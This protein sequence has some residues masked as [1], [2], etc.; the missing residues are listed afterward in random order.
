MAIGVVCV[1]RRWI[2]ETAA[3]A[4]VRVN[5]HTAGLPQGW[6]VRHNA[7][8]VNGLL[9][10]DLPLVVPRH[11][12]DAAAEGG[13]LCTV[14]VGVVISSVLC[15][16]FAAS[17]CVVGGDGCGA[18]TL[19]VVVDAGGEGGAESLCW[20]SGCVLLLLLS[21]WEGSSLFKRLLLL[22]L[23]HAKGKGRGA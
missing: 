15:P 10:G 2:D 20:R 16:C 8:R 5:G 21:S 19:C 7:L 17:K 18:G 3:C 23:L 13:N 14:T 9:F 1:G 12:A 22:L 4:L 11:A 6:L